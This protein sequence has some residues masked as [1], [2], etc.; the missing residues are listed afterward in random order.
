MSS[1]VY[2]LIRAATFSTASFAISP[3]RPVAMIRPPCFAWAGVTSAAI[4]RT[5]PLNSAIE[6]SPTSTARPFTMPT[7]AP[8]VM[9][10]WYSLPRSIMRSATCCSRDRAM[11]FALRTF[12]AV[13]SGVPSSCAM[14]PATRMRPPSSRNRRVS[15]PRRPARRCASR[16]ISRTAV[17]PKWAIFRDLLRDESHE[18]EP[19]LFRVRHRALHV[20]LVTV[21]ADP[22]PQ[23]RMHALDCVEVPRGHEDEIAGHGFR[24]HHRAGGPLALTDDGELLLLHGGQQGLLAFHAEHVDLVDEEDALVG[25]M[26]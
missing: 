25:L 23:R 5:I 10:V 15:W 11:V 16:R 12:F 4:G 6:L 22:R 3:S 21:S 18:F 9:K 19:V 2:F 14:S 26:N 17:R 8:S 7:I 20:D 1:P 24:L 13:T